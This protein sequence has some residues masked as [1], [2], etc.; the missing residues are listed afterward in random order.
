MAVS[1]KIILIPA[2]NPDE[3]MIKLVKGLQGEGFARFIVV[4][5]GSAAEFS[6]IFRRAEKLGCLVVRHEQN[7]GKG[8]A[9]KTALRAAGGR[10]GADG[11]ITVY[12]DGQH[13]PE[14]VRRIAERMDAAPNALILGTRDFHSRDV[15]VRSLLGNRITSVFFRLTSGLAC[16]DTQTGLRGSPRR[17]LNLPSRKTG[18]GMSMK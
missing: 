16:P 5:D 4:D 15:P 2:L 12:A 7:H 10:A 6:D 3:A 9:I 11:Y 13:Q 8:A 1:D 14:D 18:A 17:F